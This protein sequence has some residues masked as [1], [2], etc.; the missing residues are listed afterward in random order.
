[1]VKFSHSITKI[2]HELNSQNI[3]F[4][5]LRNFNIDLFQIKNNNLIINYANDLL[6]CSIKRLINQPT[7]NLN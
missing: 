1:M 7:R 5:V 3:E 6:S 4:Y 2:C